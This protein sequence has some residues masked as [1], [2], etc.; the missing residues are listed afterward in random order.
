VRPCLVSEE[1]K[2]ANINNI[3]AFVGITDAAL[4]RVLE[5]LTVAYSVNKLLDFIKTECS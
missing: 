1:K 4:D 3:Q 5:N 2:Y